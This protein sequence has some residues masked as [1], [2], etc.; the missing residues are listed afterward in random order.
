MAEQPAD[1]VTPPKPE[2]RPPLADPAVELADAIDQ[3]IIEVVFA[4]ALKLAR[5]QRSTVPELMALPSR[6]RLTRAAA[7]FR[8]GLLRDDLASEQ[9]QQEH[10]RRIELETLAVWRVMQGIEN[11]R[12]KGDEGRD[13][14]LDQARDN[15]LRALYPPGDNPIAARQRRARVKALLKSGKLK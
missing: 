4:V 13:Q 14:I 1:P 5:R 2:Q 8:D 9:A 3:R 7:Y 11:T 10:G 6:A 15:I 12:V